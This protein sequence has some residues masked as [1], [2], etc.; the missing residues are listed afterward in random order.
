MSDLPDS[1]AHDMYPTTGQAADNVPLAR[2]ITLPLAAPWQEPTAEWL[3]TRSTARA[4]CADLVRLVVYSVLLGVLAELALNEFVNFDWGSASADDPMAGDL[5]RAMLPS[6]LAIRA[7]ATLT[8]VWAVLRYRRQS[9]RSVGVHRD[10][11]GWNT[12]IG[13]GTTI[14]VYGLLMLVMP[15]MWMIWPDVWDLMTENAERIQN[16][17]PRLNPGGF[18]AVAL[19]VGIYEE[20]L[21]RGFLM[22]RLR[23]VT[24]SWA[25]AVIL[26]TLLFAGLHALDQ[27]APALV[28]VTILSLSFSIVTVWRRS[29]IPAIVAHTVFDL[30]QLLWLTSQ[31][32]DT[33]Q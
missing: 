24:G 17:V 16:L 4:A 26:N 23:R 19:T 27:T 20:V 21:F 33:W 28:A 12:L 3:L 22:T 25:A 9:Y 15:A 18:A 6:L 29:I 31:V 30:I 5:H 32:G 14:A 11:L 13:V 2:P 10:A 8:I 1:S 7:G